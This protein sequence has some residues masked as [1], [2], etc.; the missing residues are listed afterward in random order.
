MVPVDAHGDTHLASI[1]DVSAGCGDLAGVAL[2]GRSIAIGPDRASVCSLKC[3]QELG[4][5]DGIP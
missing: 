1:R 2:R 5:V 4:G 3:G